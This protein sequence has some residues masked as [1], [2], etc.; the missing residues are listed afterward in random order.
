MHMIM[1]FFCV[2]R[3]KNAKVF[4]PSFFSKKSGGGV[5]GEASDGFN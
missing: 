4:L 3:H 5:G 2:H 1:Q